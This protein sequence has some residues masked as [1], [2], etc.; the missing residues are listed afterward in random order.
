MEELP[1]SVGSEVVVVVVAIIA[2]PRHG[3]SA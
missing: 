3:Q 1:R 2:E